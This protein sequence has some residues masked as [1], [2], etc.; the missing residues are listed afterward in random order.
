M[1]QNPET[2]TT[3]GLALSKAASVIGELAKSSV[4]GR[5]E[6]KYYSIDPSK[7]TFSRAINPIAIQNRETND[8]GYINIV[9]QGGKFNVS[10]TSKTDAYKFASTTAAF[11][12]AKGDESIVPVNQILEALSNLKNNYSSFESLAVQSGL[13]SS[14]EEFGPI[15]ELLSLDRSKLNTE[16]PKKQ[17]K[18]RS[19]PDLEGRFCSFVSLNI[20][21][22]SRNISAD[23][24]TKS[25][26]Y[27]N[28]I[29]E[30][31]KQLESILVVLKDNSLNPEDKKSKIAELLANKTQW[32]VSVLTYDNEVIES[33]KDFDYTLN[34]LQTNT[35]LATSRNRGAY[36][37]AI[38][39]QLGLLL[40]RLS[41]IISD[42]KTK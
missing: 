12:F 25:T 8:P 34:G 35:I 1:F 13:Y 15:T 42:P 31:N 21:D 16:D 14:P 29:L 24:K 37:L 18:A 40:I 11:Y 22:T 6:P 9:Y 41:S 2:S 32:T 30:R 5:I 20:G 10:E 7:I 17:W 27:L 36:N 33:E 26:L 38:G 19:V 3:G 39:H 28:Q 23:L 4:N